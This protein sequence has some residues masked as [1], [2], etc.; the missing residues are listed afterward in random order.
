MLLAMR[1]LVPT[2]RDAFLLDDYKQLEWIA[3]YL[4]KP[5]EVFRVF[6]PYDL[7]WHYRPLHR[8][9][10]FVAR[11]IFGLS[12]AP[13]YYSL[14]ALHL[15]NTALVFQVSRKLAV[16]RFGA[17]VAAGL[18]A[19][20]AINQDVLGWISSVSTILLTLFA[21]VA[22]LQLELYLSTGRHKSWRLI[23]VALCVAAALLSREEA[24]IVPLILAAV[25]LTATRS[26]TDLRRN[27]LL[28]WLVIVAM[29]L[30]YLVVSMIRPNWVPQDDTLTAAAI[31]KLLTIDQVARYVLDMVSRFVFTNPAIL[32]QDSIGRDLL[33]GALLALYVVGLLLGNRA[34]RVGLL[35][36]GLGLAFIYAIIWRDFGVANR[37]LYLPWVG[38]AIALGAAL[39]VPSIVPA[40]R[41]SYGVIVAIG[42]LAV[43][44]IQGSQARDMQQIWHGYVDESETVR[45]QLLTMYP[46]ISP[47]AHFFAYRLPPIP[48]YVQSMA[49]VWYDLPLSGFGGSWERLLQYGQAT[50]HFYLLD[51]ADGQLSNLL[52]ELQDYN[53]TIFIWDAA[54][55]AETI[56]NDGATSPL[57]P[58]AYALNQIVGPPEARRLGMFVHPPPPAEGWASITYPV[59]I[60]EGSTLTFDTYKEWGDIESEDG[61][62]FRVNFLPDTGGGITL[63]QDSID[64]PAAEW[65][66][67]HV[68]VSQFWGQSGR[69]QFQVSANGN[70]IH[71]HAYWS[72]PRFV[73]GATAM[74]KFGSRPG[75]A[76][77]LW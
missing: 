62:I 33:A 61:M 15:V 45:Q 1:T 29:I 63:F 67:H 14:L 72:I 2:Y 76:A 11:W 30:A 52:P 8:L 69:M 34:A 38:L 37:Y 55:V 18:F 65:R 32:M 20:M 73:S 70:L 74:S 7:G 21:L 46:Q 17:A 54:P 66:N 57:D 5:W 43:V 12:P 26:V 36:W 22:M 9:F 25:W 50:E 10:F 77:H 51:F 16:T 49:S 53:E 58:G 3:R 27:E 68:D 47:E 40:R 35:W 42:L 56:G 44:S 28:F 4:A 13:Y 6:N 60:P 19:L 23:L 48:D 41:K 75:T 59:S 31:A 24:V 64:A 71:D 39:D